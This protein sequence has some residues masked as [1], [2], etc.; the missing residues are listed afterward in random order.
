MRLLL[1]PLPLPWILALRYLWSTRRDAFATFLSLVATAAIALGV[2][3][4]VLTL[5]MLSG[6]QQALG[7]E[8]L[9]RT[10]EIAVELPAGADADA[11]RGA[12]RAVPGV[13]G[14]EV[15]VRG[16]G[17]LVSG[18]RV[19][20]VELVGFDGPLPATFPGAAGGPPG[21][22]LSSTLAARWGIAV[23]EVVE[24][25]SPRPTLTPFGPQPRL[26]SLPL[27]GIFAGSTAEDWERAALPRPVAES[28]LG[29]AEHR[30]VV[31]AGGL[32]LATA[33][34]PLL[35]A[36][37]P[38]GSTVETWR[39]LNRPLLFAWQLEKL[40]TF[41]AVALVVVV[42]SLALLADLALIISSKQAEVGMLQACGA[43]PRS[44][45]QAFLA[46]GG[47]LAGLG[48]LLGGAVGVVGAIVLDRHRLLSVPGKVY[49][50]D[51]V[52]FRVL[53][54]DVAAVLAVT[55]VL[56]LGSSLYAARKATQL[57]PVEALRR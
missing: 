2:M 57:P 49:F 43:T 13:V 19:E 41:V 11:A 51:Y 46:L 44:I 40:L 36:A 25:V 53:P 30:L 54:G 37:L 26:R 31:N 29:T 18:G 3:A 42:A 17:W 48:T 7:R 5:A 33:L 16:R 47:M 20:P 34:A 21:L 23:G 8:V 22:Y 10:P 12:A 38:P 6:F 45:R 52:P 50:I 27:A 32:E 15:E 55:L 56:T 4:L 1:S 28:L 35:A 24:A 39:D 9:A 14:A